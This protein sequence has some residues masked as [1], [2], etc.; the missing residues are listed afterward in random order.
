MTDTAAA[1]EFLGWLFDLTEGPVELRAVKD[2]GGAI[3]VFTRDPEIVS[4]FLTRHDGAGRGVYFGVATRTPGTARGDRAHCTMLPALWVDG[5]YRKSGVDREEAMAA[6][7]TLPHPPSCIVASG[8]GLHSYWKLTEPIDL[9]SP[10]DDDAIT[11]TLKQLAGVCAGDPKVCDVP[12]IMRLPGT[13]NWK[14]E[15]GDGGVPCE[16]VFGGPLGEAG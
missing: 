3:S 2:E 15:L 16:V 8:G 9:T 4:V 12:R 14:P 6:L 10:D 7:M 1:L 5:D 13:V 11:A